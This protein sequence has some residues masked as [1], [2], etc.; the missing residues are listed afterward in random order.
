[1]SG[2]GRSAQPITASPRV[3]NGD[4]RGR[5]SLRKDNEFFSLD[6]RL[7]W[8]IRFGSE[9]QFE[10]LPIIEMFNT[11]NSDNLVNPLTT[12]QLFNFDGFLRKG[13]GDPRQVQFAVKIVF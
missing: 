13:V 9:G 11:T 4:D 6:W 5:N 12:A 3:L 1:M 8:P 10:L 7:Q 2:E